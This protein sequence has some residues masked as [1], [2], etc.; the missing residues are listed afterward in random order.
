MPFRICRAPF[1]ISRITQEH[2]KIFRN[3]QTISADVRL[4]GPVWAIRLGMFWN[5]FTRVFHEYAS[6]FIQL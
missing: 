3:A 4:Q 1:W 6:I 2:A 5:S